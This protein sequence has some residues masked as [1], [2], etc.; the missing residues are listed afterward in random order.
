MATMIPET[1]SFANHSEREVFD[2]LKNAGKDWFVFYSLKVPQSNRSSEPREIDFVIFIGQVVI[3]LEVKSG[4]PYAE[5]SQW[6]TGSG[7]PIESPVEQARSAMWEL[8]NHVTDHCNSEAVAKKWLESKVRYHYA[9][10][11]TDRDWSSEDPE[12]KGCLIIDSSTYRDNKRFFGELQKYADSKLPRE[13]NRHDPWRMGE[14][15]KSLTINVAMSLNPDGRLIKTIGDKQ[16]QLTEEQYERLEITEIN[17]RV[18]IRGPAGTGKTILARELAV[19]RAAKEKRV[20]LLCHTEN[21]RGWLEK[22]LPQSNVVVDVLDPAMLVRTLFG[23]DSARV[24]KYQAKHEEIKNKFNQ[25]YTVS[26]NEANSPEYGEQSI[27][28]E[29]ARILFVDEVVRDYASTGGEAP[30]NY[31]ILDEAQ[32]FGRESMLKIMDALL[33]GGLVGGRWA[34]FGDFDNQN[35]MAGQSSFKGVLD[36]LYPPPDSRTNAIPLRINCRNTQPIAEAVAGFVTNG[37]YQRDSYF[38]QVDGPKVETVYFESADEIGNNLD[39]AVKQLRQAEIS[40]QQVVVV[41]SRPLE[42]LTKEGNLDTDHKYGG[43]KLKDVSE[44]YSELSNSDLN[45]SFHPQFQGLESDVVILLL[46]SWGLTSPIPLRRRL[47][48]TAMSRAKAHLVIIADE[49]YR[50]FLEENHGES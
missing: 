16:I 47:L 46:A 43:L 5:G 4:Y 34:V 2:K 38:Q 50:D 37:Q 24:D 33:E 45:Y 17:D 28:E 11:F 9:V 49:S 27:E 35:I 31:L 15:R 39:R 20:A 30:F 12:L 22:D 44:K 25:L 41:S 13:I 19:R 32:R 18:V 26:E 1:G 6:Y 29:E 48:Y 40:P 21:M 10:L 36:R 3:C 42:E 7:E 14:L 8:K 23:S